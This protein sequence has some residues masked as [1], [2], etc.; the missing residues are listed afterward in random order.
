MSS[1]NRIIACGRLGADPE[2]RTTQG[3]DRVVSFRLACSESWTT[4]DGERKERTDWI[5]VVIW[6][7][8]LGKVAADY[9]KKGS[10]VLVEGQFQTRKWQDKD[11][12]DRYLTEC[13][14]PAYRGALTLLSRPEGASEEP[15]QR[16]ATPR[17][18]QARTGATTSGRQQ[19]NFAAELNDEVPF[20]PQVL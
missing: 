11:G 7:Q 15:E 1:Y 20:S 4:K 9:L 13:V 17:A 3:G 10:Q 8:G 12:N 2:V 16:E 14:L 18:S 5:P 19:S 6:N